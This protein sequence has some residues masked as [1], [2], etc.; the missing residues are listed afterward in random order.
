MDKDKIFLLWMTTIPAVFIFNR[1][2][3]RKILSKNDEEIL[4][5]GLFMYKGID[6]TV[7]NSLLT[8]KMTK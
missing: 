7:P 5:K 1:D 2:Y 4:G 3:I 6:D 8:G